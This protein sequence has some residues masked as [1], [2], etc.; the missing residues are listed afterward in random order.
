MAKK[1]NNNK[2]N[3]NKNNNKNNSRPAASAPRPSGGGNAGRGGGSGGGNKN[4]S[5]NKNKGQQSKAPQTAQTQRAP[6][7]EAFKNNPTAAANAQYIPELMVKGNESLGYRPEYNG[8]GW[9]AAPGGVDVAQLK[10]FYKAMA[11]TGNAAIGYGSWDQVRAAAGQYDPSQFGGSSSSSGGGGNT[12]R[13]N[14]NTAMADGKIGR[15]EIDAYMDQ[16]GIKGKK[17]DNAQMRIANRWSQKGGALGRGVAKDYAENYAKKNPFEAAYNGMAGKQMRIGSNGMMRTIEA[18][19]NDMSSRRGQKGALY[20]GLSG[21][22]NDKN[23]AKGDVF[24]TLKNGDVRAGKAMPTGYSPAGDIGNTQ[25]PGTGAGAG[26]LGFGDDFPMSDYTSDMS[27]DT[28]LTGGSGSDTGVNNLGIRR[29]KS[30]WASSGRNRSGTNNA[31]R[32]GFS[33]G[34][35]IK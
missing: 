32:S 34:L 33:S 9:A 8:D 20:R 5:I 2:N 6:Y 1:N 25:A 28:G 30:S 27:T 29:K 19:K 12:A 7:P 21:F 14:Y 31:A 17:R 22:L 4:L 13:V 10:D 26:D 3:N 16:K 18:P 11:A 24:S 15:K 23:Y 35:N